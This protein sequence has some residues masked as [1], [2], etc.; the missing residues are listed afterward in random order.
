MVMEYQIGTVYPRGR[1]VKMLAGQL[2]RVLA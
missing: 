2:D 1:N